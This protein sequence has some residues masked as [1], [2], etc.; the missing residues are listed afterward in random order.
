MVS[1]FPVNLDAQTTN[2]DTNKDNNTTLYCSACTK[3][4]SP[5]KINMCDWCDRPCH[6]KCLKNSLGCTTCCNNI[7]PGY[8]YDCY[9][10]T[11]SLLSISNRI[12]FAPYDH[13]TLTNQIGERMDAEGEGPVWTEIADQLNKCKYT[14]AKNIK[15]AKSNELKIMSLNIRSLNKSIDHIRENLNDFDKFDILCFCETNCNVDNLP[16]GTNDILIEGFYSPYTLNPHRNS[17]KGGGLAIYVNRRVCG[18][19][20][21]ELLNLEL[22]TPSSSACE[23]LFMKINIKLTTSNHK[24]TYIIGNFYRS[25]STKPDQF[26]DKLENILSKLDRHRNKQIIL[27]G[28]LNIDLV[29]HEQEQNSQQLID[30]TTR[31]GFVQV[32]NRPTRVTDH[33]ATLIDHV[34]TNQIH[35]MLSS[36]II[37]YDISDHLGIYITIAL[38]EHIG[39]NH[40]NTDGGTSSNPFSKFNAENAISSNCT[41]Q[42]NTLQSFIQLPITP[43]RTG[44]KQYLSKPVVL[45]GNIGNNK[46]SKIKNNF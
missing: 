45:M 9:Q 13:T 24:K 41:G 37:T 26:L 34:Y 14:E 32:I 23:H 22:D 17:N 3:Q 11:N 46:F 7:I 40:I 36:G 29:K 35:N 18:E 12:V 19:E 15:T 10:L 1:L 28:D 4:C 38:Q 27:T 16:N 31:C 8:N 25:P 42:F 43:Q 6:N 30:L 21:L 39:T 5:H 2:T 33:S 44:G 20:D